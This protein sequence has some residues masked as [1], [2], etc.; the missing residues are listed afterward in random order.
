[1]CEFKLGAGLSEGGWEEMVAGDEWV[2]GVWV[3][4]WQIVVGGWGGC[5]EEQWEI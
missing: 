2:A 1:M 3:W 4:F 5:V